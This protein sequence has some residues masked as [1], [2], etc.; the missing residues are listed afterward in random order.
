MALYCWLVWPYR[1]GW[2]GLIVVTGMALYRI[3]GFFCC[4]FISAFSAVSFGTAEIKAAEYFTYL[5]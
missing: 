4:D 3:S 1:S 2:Y 5:Q